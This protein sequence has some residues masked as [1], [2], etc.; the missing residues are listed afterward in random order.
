MRRPESR[1][2][3][4]IFGEAFSFQFL[5]DRGGEVLDLALPYT[6]RS[7]AADP[8]GL[9][10][11]PRRSKLAKPLDSR[12]LRRSWMHREACFAALE[13]LRSMPG[14]GRLAELILTVGRH[15]LR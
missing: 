10:A 7:V 15:K 5:F 12:E 6:R 1:C 13:L 9:T 14:P 8:A 4:A 11:L 2:G 3:V